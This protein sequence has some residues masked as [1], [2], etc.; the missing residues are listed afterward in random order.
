MINDNQ[1]HTRK[2][3]FNSD[4]VFKEVSGELQFVG[5]F[6]SLYRNNDDPW[7]Q[8]SYEGE[9]GAYYLHSRNRLTKELKKEKVESILEVGC[10]LGFSTDAINK[11]TK[12]LEIVGMDISDTAIKK[13]RNI[14]PNFSFVQGDITSN[15]FLDKRFDV[16][17]MNQ[18]LWYILNFF[19]KAV[20]NCHSLLKEEGR[21]IFSQAFLIAEQ[22]YGTDI[23]NGFYGLKL[24][25]NRNSLFKLEFSD[26]DINS[27]LI[28]NDGIVSLRKI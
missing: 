20:S 24:L 3:P 18:I 13:A 6:E 27:P 25:L 15:I 8:S 21:L 26:L 16:V 4:Y 5:D 11:S 7:S 10:G 2:H 9:M 22:K 14:F 1:E 17:I 28:H 12:A 19:P 23:C